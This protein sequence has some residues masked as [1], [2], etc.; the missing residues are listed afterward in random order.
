MQGLGRPPSGGRN[1]KLFSALTTYK[2]RPV[3]MCHLLWQL[4]FREL[5]L[6]K[7][8]ALP[9]ATE[10]HGRFLDN[11]LWGFTSDFCKFFNS[12]ALEHW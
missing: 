1:Q 7:R 3:T 8:Y 2:R 10:R 4:F 6:L 12:I 9:V 11:P 5:V